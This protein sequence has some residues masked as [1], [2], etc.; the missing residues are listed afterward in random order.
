[1]CISSKPA[2]SRQLKTLFFFVDIYSLKMTFD[3]KLPEPVETK[4]QIIF[5]VEFSN[6]QLA[7]V[8]LTLVTSSTM[9][10]FSSHHTLQLKKNYEFLYFT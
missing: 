3:R 1:M 2:K 5:L 8:G 9:L 10:S 6:F 4:I 7:L